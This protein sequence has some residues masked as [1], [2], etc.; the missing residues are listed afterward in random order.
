[1]KLKKIE[2][3]KKNIIQKKAPQNY[4]G[5]CSIGSFVMKKNFVYFFW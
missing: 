3:I 1:M 4:F 5:P 2:K